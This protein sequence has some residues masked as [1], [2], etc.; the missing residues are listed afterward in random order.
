[1]SYSMDDDSVIDIAAYCKVYD[2]GDPFTVYVQFFLAAAA[3]MSLWFKRRSE[4]PMRS[5]RTW[6]LDVTKMGTGAVYAHVANMAVAKVVSTNT[7]KGASLDDECA[8]YGMNF[9]IDTTFGLLLSV[10]FLTA[11]SKMA[12]KWGWD[13][14]KTSGDY[15]GV[16]GLT[17]WRN[18]LAS[19]LGILSLSKVILTIGLWWW[20]PFFATAGA[21]IFKPLQGSPQ[22]ELIF[23]MILFPGALNVVYF[24]L[25][26]SFLK[27]DEPEGEEGDIM[28]VDMPNSSSTAMELGIKDPESSLLGDTD[29]HVTSPN[30]GPLPTPASPGWLTNSQN[31]AVPPPPAVLD[32]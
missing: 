31:G 22:F 2:D 19:W 30:L 15:S 20:S 28:L 21:I 24:W 5:F 10:L 26:D 25:A 8:W 7:R 29:D 16:N 23:V 13:S 3:L 27:N 12:H 11:L 32:L 4:T 18:Q 14:L 1:M 9:L 17:A 6:F